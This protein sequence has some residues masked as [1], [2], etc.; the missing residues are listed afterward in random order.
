MLTT[1]LILSLCQVPYGPQSQWGW[2]GTVENRS[3][4]GYRQLF[5]AGY[6]PPSVFY[7]GECRPSGCCSSSRRCSVA[8]VPTQNPWNTAVAELRAAGPR[9]SSD[10]RPP[11]PVVYELEQLDSRR[12][13][14][15][16]SLRDAAP[17]EKADLRREWLQA[18]DDLEKARIQAARVARR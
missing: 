10:K 18:R 2:D 11:T 9:R 7:G 5:G 14:L 8:F 13:D 4:F 15:Y 12:A 1:I 6:Y 16:A 17:E 3:G